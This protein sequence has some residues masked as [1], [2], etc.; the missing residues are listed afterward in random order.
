MKNNSKLLAI[1]AAPLICV[2]LI[3]LSVC[4]PLVME[5]PGAK[6]VFLPVK[7]P[8]G[9]YDK[10]SI[11]G[12]KARE[13][14]IETKRRQKLHAWYFKKPGALF[15]VIFHHGRGGNLTYCKSWAKRFLDAGTS[16]VL[17]D[18][19]GF[20]KSDGESTFKNVT[21]DAVS[22]Y[23]YVLS[24]IEPEPLV[25][26]NAG[27]SMGCAVASYVAT[28]KKC[29]GL[30]ICAPFDSL[31]SLAKRNVFFWQLSPDSMFSYLSNYDVLANIRKSKALTL[32]LYAPKDMM[33]GEA[34]NKNLLKINQPN[35][36]CLPVNGV[37]HGNF[38]NSDLKEHINFFFSQLTK[39]APKVVKQ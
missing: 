27:F 1:R 37:G 14:F 23:D 30:I 34:A 16:V 36:L 7:W 19:E 32:V 17:Y 15:T 39:P 3:V 31:T 11:D 29:A 33:M 2:L 9:Y 21:A 28:E 10:P 22:V 20:G 4:S 38:L 5:G 26:V 18:Y 25:I 24:K 13:I 8:A 12:I 6:L 35:V